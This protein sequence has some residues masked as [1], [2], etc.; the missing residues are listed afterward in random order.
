VERGCRW[1]SRR[2]SCGDTIH[3]GEDLYEDFLILYVA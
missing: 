2:K 3:F 1:S